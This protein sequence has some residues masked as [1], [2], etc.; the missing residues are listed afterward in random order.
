VFRKVALAVDAR[1]P[2]QVAFPL[3]ADSCTDALVVPDEDVGGLDVEAKDDH[4]RLIARGVS[5]DRDRALT[6]CSPSGWNGSLS[7]R[8]HVGQG[9][10]AVVLSRGKGDAAKALTV[11]PDLAWAA[12]VEPLDKARKERETVLV[13][14]G[15]G[16]PQG[17]EAGALTVGALRSVSATLGKRGGG[18]CWRIDLVG[19]APTALVSASVWDEHGALVASSEGPRAAALFACGGGVVRV[20]AEARAR[21]GPFAMVWRPEPWTDAS[22]ATSPVAAAR[23][24]TRTVSGSV[25]LLLEGAAAGVRAFHALA[26][27]EAAW[28]E[29]VPAGACTRV[30][31]GAEGEGA[32]LI[33]RVVDAASGDELDRGHGAA[34]LELRACAPA[35]APK[36]VRVSLSV[37]AGTMNLVAGSRTVR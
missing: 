10:V 17:S 2:A 29:T 23:M 19:G 18:G 30:D 12:A 25:P 20:D 34:S 37:T 31:V 5:G 7:V 6:V 22:F 15:Y 36:E 26:G 13:G 14:A 27:H 3:D 21:A 9:L 16:P 33:G 28:T 4:G 35:D 24:L 1:V 11:A 32:G 8:P